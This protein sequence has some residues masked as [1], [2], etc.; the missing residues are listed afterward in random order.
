MDSEAPI[1][2]TRRGTTRWRKTVLILTALLPLTLLLGYFLLTSG[3]T[4]RWIASKIQARAGGLQATVGSVTWSPWNGV[5]INSLNLLQPVPLRTLIKEP[6]LR[7]ESVQLAPVWRAW[8]RGKP[9]V[10]SITLDNPRFVLP[11]EL[12]SELSRAASPPKPVPVP[13]PPAATP[14]PPVVAAQPMPPTP[15]PTAS[16]P[17]TPPA[18]NPAPVAP[19]PAP[20]GWLHLRNAS[21]AL[22]QAGSHRTLLEI[23]NT[24]G[25]IPIAGDASQAILKIG[26]LSVSNHEWLANIEANLDWT[27]PMLS[28]KPLNLEIGGYKCLVAGKVAKYS[29]FPYQIEAQLPRQPL[30]PVSL[31]FAGHATAEA[32]TANARLRGLLLAPGTWQGDLL[33]EAASPTLAFASHEAKFD[34][35]SAVTV[36]RGGLL[37]C[38]DA[39]MIGDELS[40]LGNAT[41][42]ADGRA[43]G[44]ARVVATPETLHAIAKR[45]FPILQDDVSLTLLAT[46]QRAA[47]DVEAFGNI[48]QL[49][50]RLGKEGPVVNLNH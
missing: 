18:P 43:A 8:I 19:P 9:E 3:F 7:I 5:S 20:T 44:A 28:L 1:G 6:L 16:S 24:S 10:Q 39:R 26:K 23:S 41:V 50:L 17:A 47:F 13:T 14:P 35:G 33:T 48:H 22:V 38:V 29:G 11:V 37:S 12:I 32:I 36:L 4:S 42:L 2:D 31:P 25:S 34:K 27:A 15:A 46:P 30:R 49:F 21:L 40:L 45:A